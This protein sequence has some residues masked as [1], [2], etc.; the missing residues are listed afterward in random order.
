MTAIKD[1]SRMA[2]Q[3]LCLIE[4][5]YD[6]IVKAGNRIAQERIDQGLS[7]EALAE[8][9]RRLGGEI[10]Q[11]GIDK[12]EKRDSARP[13]FAKEIATAL[14]VS[15]DWLIYG[16]M[17]KKR[18]VQTDLQKAVAEALTFDEAEQ[19]MILATLQTMIDVARQ[20][21]AKLSDVQTSANHNLRRKK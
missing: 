12:L 4:G 7:Q 14:G 8:K 13:R 17:P 9:V 3:D 20:R 5:C 11:G 19:Q 10:T 15:E 21:H 16:K 2:C 18:G 6:L 1:I